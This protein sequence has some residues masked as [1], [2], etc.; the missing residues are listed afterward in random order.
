MNILD[1][2]AHQVD[3]ENRELSLL[4]SLSQADREESKLGNFKSLEVQATGINDYMVACG[5]V[6]WDFVKID[7]EGWEL[8][9]LSALT[10]DNFNKIQR[11]SIELHAGYDDKELLRFL[12]EAGFSIVYFKEVKGSNTGFIKAVRA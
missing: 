2:G 12:K 8:K 10:R 1:I 6:S 11:M 9:I 3:N 4:A 5:V 7:T